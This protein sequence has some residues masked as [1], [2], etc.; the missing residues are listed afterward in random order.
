MSNI[1]QKVLYPCRVHL[2]DAV[3]ERAGFFPFFDRHGQ[4]HGYMLVWPSSSW[5]VWLDAGSDPIEGI[6]PLRLKVD[7]G[8][9]QDM[10][11]HDLDLYPELW[12][13]DPWWLLREP[14]Y[15]G[16][17]AV[18]PLKA[19]N[20]VRYLKEVENAALFSSDLRTVIGPITDALPE[21]RDAW[22]LKTPAAQR[23]LRRPVPSKG[24]VRWRLKRT[25]PGLG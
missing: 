11:P 15:K 25:W 14:R 5:I 24:R 19:T 9:L 10:G 12:H 6:R 13:Y 2:R 4:V 7:F 16:H 22:E 20:A 18:P 1:H 23:G 21:S 3:L 17:P 8:R